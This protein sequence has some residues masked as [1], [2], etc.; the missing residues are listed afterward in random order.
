MQPEVIIAYQMN[1]ADIP[2]DHGYPIRII[3]PGVVGARQVKWVTTIRT[4]DV[5]SPSHWQQKDYK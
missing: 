1:D 4:S 3:A 2:A 5:E